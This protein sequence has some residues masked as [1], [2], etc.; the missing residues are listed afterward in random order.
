MGSTLYE[1]VAGRAPYSELNAIESDD[2]D[3]IKAQIR[4]QHEVV[5]FEIEQ[6]F[7]EQQFPDVTELRGGDIILGC[8][9]GQFATAKEALD[10]YL[11]N[12]YFYYDGLV[13]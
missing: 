5:D 10:L 2:P 3:S 12:T 11:K 4:R 1:L 6:R 9:R 8:W 7:K 13:V